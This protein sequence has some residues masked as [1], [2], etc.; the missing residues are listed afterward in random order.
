M[1]R[2][3]FIAAIGSAGVV[4]PLAT[5]AQNVPNVRRIVV[6]SQ[7]SIHTHPSPQFGVFLQTLRDAGWIEGQNLFI[8][9]RFSE[10]SAEPLPRLAAELVGRGV[11][12]IVTTPT[13]PTMAAKKA[14]SAVPIVF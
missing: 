9:W 14:T 2:R 7:G 11:E 10:G 6:L 1:R 8:D 13:E 12:L 5:Q 4:C 3:D